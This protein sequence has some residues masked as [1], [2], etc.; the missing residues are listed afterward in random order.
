MK[1]LTEQ[2]IKNHISQLVAHFFNYEMR[3]FATLLQSLYQSFDKTDVDQISI[4]ANT[5]I[6]RNIRLQVQ[7]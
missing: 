6:R 2:K 3:E 1:P 4:S 5:Y 7:K